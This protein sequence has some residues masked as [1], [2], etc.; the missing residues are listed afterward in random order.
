[1]S[2]ELEQ[3]LERKL[4]FISGKGGTGK[5]T[6][7]TILADYAA[8][9][10]KRVLLVEQTGKPLLPFFIGDKE[11]ENITYLNLSLEYCFKE[12]VCEYLGQ[13]FLYEKVFDN[14]SI[15]TFLKTIPGLAEAMVIGKLYYSLEKESPQKYDLAI[16]DCPASGHFYNLLMTPATIKNS[17]LGGPFLEYM[18][19]IDEFIRS[20]EASTIFMTLPEPLV[21]TETFEF[22]SKIL[23]EGFNLDLLVKNKWLTNY[24]QD[25]SKLNLSEGSKL[26]E[27]LKNDIFKQEESEKIL[28]ELSERLR[29][30]NLV[31]VKMLYDPKLKAP[32]EGVKLEDI[33][34]K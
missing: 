1:M 16:F 24:G 31:Q 33:L 32:V 29:K 12:F 23:D 6:F 2:A 22:L 4:L 30:L 17:A 8:S 34:N 20:E 18:A 19:V 28:V 15:K 5:S 9:K 14:D 26:A 25:S 7:A 27:F 21:A 10:G 13:P 3:L 11:K